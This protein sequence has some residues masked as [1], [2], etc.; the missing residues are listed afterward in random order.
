MVYRASRAQHRCS[1]QQ[2][3][4]EFFAGPEM[5]GVDEDGVVAIV[6]GSAEDFM[7]EAATYDFWM[8]AINRLPKKQKAV[9]LWTIRGLTQAEVAEKM[10]TNQS[11][12]SYHLKAARATLNALRK[13]MA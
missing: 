6:C 1:S 11:N 7:M 10:D 9:M 12:I 4:M 8:Q 2:A 3:N 5:K 13:A